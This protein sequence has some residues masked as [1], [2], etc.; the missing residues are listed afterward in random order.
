M[1]QTFM[2]AGEISGLI[3]N[4]L[5]MAFLQTD[6]NWPQH[7]EV[8]WCS[9]FINFVCKSCRVIRSKSLA[10]R[11]WLDFGLPIQ[12]N[13]AMIGFDIVILERGT[14]GHVGFFAGTEGINKVR[15]LAGNQGNKVSIDSFPI[16]RILGIRRLS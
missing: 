13:E 14:G 15:L 11:S 8:P 10:A 1:A 16:S 12:L 4:P 3:D 7:D 5:I 6:T 2:G 9:G